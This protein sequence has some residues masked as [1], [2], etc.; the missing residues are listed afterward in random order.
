MVATSILGEDVK[1]MVRQG[2]KKRMSFGFCLDQKNDPLLMIEPGKKPENLR[3]SLK[4]AGGIPPMIWGTYVVR[5]DQMEMI[6][7]KAS[8]KIMQHLKKFFGKHRPK[9][10]VLFYDNGGNLLDSLKPEGHGNEDTPD[11]VTVSGPDAEEAKEMVARLKTIH[12]RI[13][14]APGPLE[15]K[16]KR[17]M[18]KSV[19]LLNDRLLQEAETL[20]TTIEMALAKIGK[21]YEDEERTQK[22]AQRSRDKLSLN[23][24]MERARAL[25]E[26]SASAP[27]PMRKKLDVA[28]QKAARLLEDRD[29]E[30]ASEIMDK[31]EKAL[32]TLS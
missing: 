26:K 10:N 20:I 4:K 21:T 15:L 6:L 12:P 25:R 14:L 13:A 3:N 19:Q 16:L 1:I 5:M 32:T 24:S 11:E 17:A 23:D 29:L 27:G 18:A 9:V 2:T 8:A 28:V 7:E 31:I 22:R 30:G